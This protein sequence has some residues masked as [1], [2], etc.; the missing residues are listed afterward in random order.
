M[1][2]QFYWDFER[3]S[4]DKGESLT[5]LRRSGKKGGTESLIIAGQD[6]TLN[7]LYH[8]RNIME[9]PTDSTRG[10]DKFLARTTSRCRMTESIVSLGERG[11]VC[12]SNCKTFLVT[13]AE[14][15]HVRRRA[16]FQQ[17]G[18]M[19]CH[20]VPPTPPCNATCRR[21]YAPFGQ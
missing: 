17:H 14:R 19:S 2:G 18:D 8:D 7:T 21:K 4:T 10:A 15:K 1:H 12:V 5:S 6:Q 9:Q 3:P 16:R 13:E 20:Q 11:S